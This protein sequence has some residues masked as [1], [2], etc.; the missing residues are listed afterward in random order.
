M[1]ATAGPALG[2][3]SDAPPRLTTSVMTE[4]E[5]YHVVVDVAPYGTMRVY[6]PE[7]DRDLLLLLERNWTELWSS[8][9]ARLEARCKP[10][11]LTAHLE[12]IA[13]AQPISADAYMGDK[14]ELLLSLRLGDTRPQ[15]D[16]F[17]NGLTIVHFQPVY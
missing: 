2:C 14:A 10:D 11:D 8:V 5:P 3:L 1:Q 7:A 6:G 9:R 17:L 16:F 12:W 13:A 15:W 4:A